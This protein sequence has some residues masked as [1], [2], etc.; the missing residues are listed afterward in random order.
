MTLSLR[1]LLKKPLRRIELQVKS[2]IARVLQ[3]SFQK[4]NPPIYLSFDSSKSVDGT[5]AQLQRQ[6]TVMAVAK[7]FGFTY[8]PAEIKQVSVHPLD[9]FQSEPEYESYLER[10][11]QF[12]KVDSPSF[13][14]SLAPDVKLTS[15]TFSRLTREYFYQ[16]LWRRERN[17]LIYEPYP[18]SEFCPRIMDDLQLQSSEY[19]ESK[20]TPAVFEIVIH[21]RQGVGGFVLYPGQNIPR[22]IPVEVF[23]ARVRKIA[24][25]LPEGLDTQVIVVTD[26]P[27]TETVFV[28]PANQLALWEGTPG[29]SNG[30]MTIKPTK[31]EELEKLSKL[32]LK[33]LRGGNPLDTILL[34]ASADVLLTG[35]SSLS[36][37]GGL[38]NYK[39][40]VYFPK[41][42]WHRPLRNWQVL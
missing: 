28:P 9:P 2:L 37:L 31:F 15:L 32:P 11:N 8:V 19:L 26:A 33:V 41:D 17:F 12:L 16:I 22:E 34:M 13:V 35:K 3:F 1:K 4:I 24:L 5:G 38:L 14:R 10:L 7:Y 23:A 27:D 21:Y 6:A 30:V 40:Q 18:V 42:F 36:Y 20:K 29:F 39:G 25:S